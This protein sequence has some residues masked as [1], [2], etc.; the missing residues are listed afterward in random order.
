MGFKPLFLSLYPIRKGLSKGVGKQG[1][2]L[3]EVLIALVLIATFSVIFAQF[4]W[5]AVR[6]NKQAHDYLQAVNHAS[7]FM[8][9]LQA[10]GKLPAGSPRKVDK[11]TLSWKAMPL[12]PSGAVNTIFG[13]S[14][15][16]VRFNLVELTVAWQSV[17]G[18]DTSI[19]IVSGVRGA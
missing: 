18:G 2:L 19:K 4:Q 11:F 3:I 14:V 6:Q 7:A 10:T 15:H 5:Q 9:K 13:S 1:F 12:A 17:Q 8:E 16:K